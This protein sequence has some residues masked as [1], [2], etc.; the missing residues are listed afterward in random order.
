MSVT[1]DHHSGRNPL[2]TDGRGSP[3]AAVIP[4][5]LAENRRDER[6]RRDVP[7]ARQP[8]SSSG[9]AELDFV[10]GLT[11]I[12]AEQ[13]PSE[14]KSQGEPSAVPAARAA[15]CQPATALV[16][17][18]PAKWNLKCSPAVTSVTASWAER[19]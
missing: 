18:A 11:E 5:A 17:Y 4:L 16:T 9:A 10:T 1:T 3:P 7:A 12:G 15:G 2:A 19:P 6:G 8:P 13:C 14:K